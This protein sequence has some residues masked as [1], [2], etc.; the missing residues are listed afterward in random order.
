MNPRRGMK[1]PLRPAHVRAIARKEVRHVLRD[2]RSLVVA[3]LMPLM[4]I[5]IYGYA[6]DMEIKNVR[7]AV[8]DLD[9]SAD[10]RALLRRMTSSGFIVHAGVLASRAEIEPGFRAGRFRA[11][12]IVP[13]G[14]AA[15]LTRGR[16][17]RVQVL[18]DGA[19]ASTAASVE[20]YLLA[21]TA[22]PPAAPPPID[23]RPR[24]FFNPQLESADFIVP[25]LM[26]VILTMICA[27]L[28]S[29]AITREKETGTLEQILTTPVEPAEVMV[30]KVLPYIV[31]AALDAALVLG[32]G[33]V[34]FGVPLRGSPFALAGY[35]LLYL[36]IVLAF[37][38]LISTVVS[39]QRVAM[40][41]ALMATFLPTMLLSGFIF[42]HSSMPLPLRLIGK[43]IPATHFLVIV[44]GV[45]LKG[46][47]WFPLEFTVLAVMAV[48]FMGLAVRRF[49]LTLE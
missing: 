42:D 48:A 8:L 4:M 40:M 39:T 36:F 3:I 12:L 14:F 38:L 13:A 10:S 22:L 37:G 19:D 1:R 2:P 41:A 30:G 27:L 29:I 7:V 33:R 28:T 46:E 32:A 47:S 6:V 9:R 45:M 15:H 49:R 35:S 18:V 43:I 24:V 23:M 5:M 17:A 26:A 31:I 16:T 44:R 11:A 21:A 25:G 20:N 34:L